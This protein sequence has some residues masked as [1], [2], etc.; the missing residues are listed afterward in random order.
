MDNIHAF[1][2]QEKQDVD[3]SYHR[4][5]ATTNHPIKKC[6]IGH[7]KYSLD[8]KFTYNEKVIWKEQIQY[9]VSVK[10]KKNIDDNLT[11]KFHSKI[12]GDLN[13]RKITVRYKGSLVAS[14]ADEIQLTK[15]EYIQ[16][17]RILKFNRIIK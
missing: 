4:G 13:L 3:Y 11:E 7:Y 9:Y 6:G 15:E 5:S 2:W 8:I 17:S 1:K 14:F 16:F 10:N 12:F